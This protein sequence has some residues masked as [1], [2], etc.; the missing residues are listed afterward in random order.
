ME[1]AGEIAVVDSLLD[2]SKSLPPREPPQPE[3]HNEALNV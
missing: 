2:L 3:A 1:E